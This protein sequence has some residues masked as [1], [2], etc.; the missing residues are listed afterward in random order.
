MV[1]IDHEAET[2]E[3]A[4]RRIVELDFGDAGLA[5]LHVAVA[6]RKDA[7]IEVRGSRHEFSPRLQIYRGARQLSRATQARDSGRRCRIHAHS[8]D[9][10]RGRARRKK[11]RPLAA[12]GASN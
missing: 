9:D 2:V 3:T 6:M 12:A 8:I 4:F 1:R 5:V 7:D 10:A 11:P